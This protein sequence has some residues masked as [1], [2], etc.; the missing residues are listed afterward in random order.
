[1]LFRF[2]AGSAR[3]SICGILYFSQVMRT[4][5]YD[6]GY[7]RGRPDQHVLPAGEMQKRLRLERN[8]D[9]FSHSVAPKLRFSVLQ[10]PGAMVNL[11]SDDPAAAVERIEAVAFRQK[12]IECSPLSR[13]CGGNRTVAPLEC[14]WSG[15][16]VGSLASIFDPVIVL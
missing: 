16:G 13:K 3:Q 6:S 10:R 11:A 12:M 2:S 1:M 5:G 15:A 14:C 4:R 7:V 8:S 9:R